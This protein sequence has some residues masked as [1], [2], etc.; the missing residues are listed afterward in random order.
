MSKTSGSNSIRTQATGPTFTENDPAKF[1]NGG[2][3]RKASANGVVDQGTG[4]TFTENSTH[5]PTMDADKP[6]RESKVIRT[7]KAPQ[8][9]SD[10]DD[11]CNASTGG[12]SA[13]TP[14]DTLKASYEKRGRR[15]AA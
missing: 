12:T 7:G 2:R 10:A 4:P 8:F 13:G 3:G 1:A 5:I 6:P 15:S 11:A 9:L 14:D